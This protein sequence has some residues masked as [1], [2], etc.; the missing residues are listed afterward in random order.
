MG[1]FI[2]LGNDGFASALRSTL[3]RTNMSSIALYLGTRYFDI[4]SK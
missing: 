2:N 1:T 3:P 4:T